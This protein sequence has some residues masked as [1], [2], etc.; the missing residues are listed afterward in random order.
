MMRCELTPSILSCDAACVAPAVEVMMRA[1]AD[2]FLVVVM[3]GQFVPPITFGHELARSLAALGPVPLEAHLMT[4]TPERHFDAFI[5]AGCKR[6]TFHAE[7]APHAHR[8]AQAL[9]A[10]GVKAGIAI[11]PGTPASA[12][13]SVLDVVDLVLVMT[14]NP[15]WGGQAFIESALDKIAALREMSGSVTIQ[16]DGGIDPEN[17]RRT[18][19]AGA[20]AFVAGSYVMRQPTIA[21]AMAALREACA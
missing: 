15:G 18:R 10:A 11:N 8:L 4:L 7:A 14:V 17:L 13:E 5:E 6:V 1:G 2:W 21:R 9:H 16:V 19:A 12:V 20:N 3:D